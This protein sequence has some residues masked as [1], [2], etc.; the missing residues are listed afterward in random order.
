MHLYYVLICQD[1]RNKSLTPCIVLFTLTEITVASLHALRVEGSTRAMYGSSIKHWFEFV[2]QRETIAG[3]YLMESCTQ[4]DKTQFACIFAAYCFEKHYSV[5]SSFSAL[6]DYFISNMRV[7]DFIDGNVIVQSARSAV[8]KRLLNLKKEKSRDISSPFR[9]GVPKQAPTAY[10]M[11]KDLRNWCVGLN[12]QVI[13]NNW[14]IYLGVAVQYCFGLRA[15][16]V[17][18]KGPKTRHVLNSNDVV[19]E[20]VDHRFFFRHEVSTS[21]CVASDFVA[22]HLLPETCKTG[23]WGNEILSVHCRTPEENL[24]QK[25]L[26]WWSLVTMANHNELFFSHSYTDS[27]GLYQNKKLI[28][29]EVSTAMKQTASR[30]GLDPDWYTTHCNRIGAATDLSAV[31][32]KEE[33]LK[34]LGWTSDAG[35]SYARI[36]SRENSFS[37]LREQKNLTIPEI[38]RMKAFSRASSPNPNLSSAPVRSVSQAVS[39]GETG[40]CQLSGLAP[41]I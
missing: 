12:N 34:V 33:A 5:D 16:N 36:G 32:G 21:G 17:C 28:N 30:L 10:E 4:E 1:E 15:S 7:V 9:L 31:L 13:L 25:D 8:R 38:L 11:I 6:R 40:Q 35:L 37:I 26:I 39:T 22:V 27:K 3:N 2:D 29:R 19:Y 24:L 14:Q 20:T 18:W 41:V 23:K